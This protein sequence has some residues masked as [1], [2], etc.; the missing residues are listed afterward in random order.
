MN[1]VQA[2]VDFESGEWA[3]REVPVDLERPLIVVVGSDNIGN[4]TDP[5]VLDVVVP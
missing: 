4:T 2:E 1:G 3:A 5:I